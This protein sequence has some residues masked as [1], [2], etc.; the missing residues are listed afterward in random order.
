M[1]KLS[2]Y[3]Q[4]FVKTFFWEWKYIF[5]DGAV[6]SSF[7]LVA[8]LVSFLYTYLY[9]RE[10]LQE[11]PIGVVDEDNTTGSRQ[12]LRMLDATSQIVI[13]GSYAN[14]Q[15][16]EQEFKKQHI[17]GIVIVPKDFNKD[18]QRGEQPV[19]SVFTDA[20]YLLYHKQVLTATKVSAAYMNAGIQLKKTASQ[21]KLPSQAKD[22]TMAVGSKVV[23]LYNPSL[24]YATFLIPAVLVIIFQT[25]ILTA[26]GILGG[27]MREEKKFHRLYADSSSFIGALFVTMGKATAYLILGLI[28]LLI[29]LGIVMPIFGIPMRSSF[30]SVIAYMI[31]FLLAVVFLGIFLINFF[32]RREDAILLV[33]YTSIPSIL[34]TGVAWP[35]QAMPQWLEKLSYLIPT[36]LGTK[37]FISMTQMGATLPTIQNYW[38]GMW[39]L[40][41]F[42]ITLA[43]VSVR[44]M[45]KE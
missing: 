26:I 43:V 38:L 19:I 32:R 28:I 24:G 33:M 11:L 21:G 1:K 42:Y 15:E 3:S 29:M 10:T 37:G 2:D 14:L 18:L 7:I 5:R 41:F 17:R 34:L 6:F 12:F 16:A 31:P 27:T 39:I 20:S 35:V 22:E 23:S 13:T 40:C 25:T 30:L 45:V 8:V 9:S 44:K 4:V 36:T